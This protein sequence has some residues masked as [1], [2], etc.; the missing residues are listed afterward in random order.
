MKYFILYFVH[1]LMQIKNFKPNSIYICM[2]L[3]MHAC[4]YGTV[5]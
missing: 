3:C 4:I 5:W 1:V 2:Y